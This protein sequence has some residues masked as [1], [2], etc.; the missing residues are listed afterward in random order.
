MRSGNT[1]AGRLA[2]KSDSKSS[3][4]A[5]TDSSF[6]PLTCESRIEKLKEWIL[7]IVLTKRIFVFDNIRIP[8]KNFQKD[9]FS[10]YKNKDEEFFHKFSF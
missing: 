8:Q 7:E 2:H 10:M 9:S 1:R 5:R 6:Q 3:R 4:I